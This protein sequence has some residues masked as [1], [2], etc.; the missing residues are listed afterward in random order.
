MA[1]SDTIR[2]DSRGKHLN[3]KFYKPDNP[4]GFM[5]KAVQIL[6][7]GHQVSAKD[8]EG[9]VAYLADQYLYHKDIEKTAPGFASVRNKLG[10]LQ[11]RI[12][13]LVTEIR[14]LDE[15]TVSA[16]AGSSLVLLLEEEELESERFRS[17]LHNAQPEKFCNNFRNEDCNA[18]SMWI[19]K[20]INMDDYLEIVSGFLQKNKGYSDSGPRNGPYLNLRGTPELRLVMDG[21]SEFEINGLKPSATIGSKFYDFIN[22]IRIYADEK[23]DRDSDWVHSYA[24]KYKKL[25]RTLEDCEINIKRLREYVESGTNTDDEFLD[26]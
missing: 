14:G 6:V 20:L 21:W 8:A 26:P 18:E 5:D 7:S 24:V 4:P 2:W 17:L 15:V 11:K 3:G 19:N 9:I 12:R 13:D 23:L 25:V 1:N 10:V 16:I 22:N